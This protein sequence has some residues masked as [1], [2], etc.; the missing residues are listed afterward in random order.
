MADDKKS[1]AGG[2]ASAAAPSSSSKAGEDKRGTPAD[3][4]KG[5][6]LGGAAGSIGDT[7]RRKA[8]DPNVARAASAPGATGISR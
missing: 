7:E 1:K 5:V 8:A 2:S 4:G 3:T 6:V